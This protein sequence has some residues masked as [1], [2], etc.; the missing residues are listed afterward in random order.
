[1]VLRRWVWRLFA[2]SSASRIEVSTL[3][4]YIPTLR[5]IEDKAHMM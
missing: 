3:E 4:A 2:G 5:T 1:V